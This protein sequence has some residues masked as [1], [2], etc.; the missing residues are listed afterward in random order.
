[1]IDGFQWDARNMDHMARHR[2]VPAEVEEI[3]EG[4]YFLFKA[5]TGRYVVL[6]QTATDRGLSCVFEKTR[7]PGEIRVITARDMSDRE[8]QLFRRKVG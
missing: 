2:V 8:R 3:F 6:G 5:W 4:R 1:M 7:R